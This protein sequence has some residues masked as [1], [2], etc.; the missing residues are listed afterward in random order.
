MRLKS[1]TPQRIKV[2]DTPPTTVPAQ[3]SVTVQIS[4]EA[5]SNGTV[6]VAAQLA[7]N[8]GTPIGPEHTFVISAS[9]YG[10]VGWIIIVAAGAVVLVSTAWRVRRFRQTE[11][12]VDRSE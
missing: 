1:Q 11:R 5:T 4:P 10:N 8:S 9:G 7:T 2:T 6:E 12:E 3:E